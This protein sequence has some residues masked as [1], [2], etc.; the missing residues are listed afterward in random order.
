[1]VDERITGFA[2]CGHQK[3]DAWA[4]Q[5][6]LDH[7]LPLPEVVLLLAYP[8]EA[9]AKPKHQEYVSSVVGFFEKRVSASTQRG[10]LVRMTI[11]KTTPRI[12]MTEL[13]SDPA[14]ALTLLTSLL[15][16]TGKRSK[17]DPLVFADDEGPEKRCRVLLNKTTQ[18]FRDT[19]VNGTYIGFPFLV[20]K[21]V[22]EQTS[23]R[24]APILLWPVTLAGAV[25]TRGDYTLAFDESRGEVRLNPAFEGLLGLDGAAKWKEVAR[26]LMSNSSLTIADVVG[27]FASL[28]EPQGTELEAL[29]ATSS[30]GGEETDQILCSAVLFHVEFIGQALVEDLRHL[31]QRPVDQ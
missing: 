22:R 17:I 5:F 4:D 12:D 16:R 10:P 9:W 8:A 3:L 27:A 6:R 19:G 7:R 31:K 21:P 26:D 14:K 20:R 2:R 24:L 29:P 25:G 11:G 18:Y 1:L 30:L 23:P 15:Q 28:A 13:G